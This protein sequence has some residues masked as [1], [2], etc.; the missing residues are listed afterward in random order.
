M[1]QDVTLP[2]YPQSIGAK[3]LSITDHFGP[4]SYNATT[5]DVYNVAGNQNQGG[6]DKV[7]A[8]SSLDGLYTVTS[9]YPA[10]TSAGIG[11]TSVSLFWTFATTG[12]VASVTGT[13]GTGMTVGSFPLVIAA[14]P[15]GG[16]QA[17]GT[18]TVLTATTFTTTISNPGAGYTSAPA[19][20]AATGGTPPT[21]TANLSTAGTAVA[22]GANLSASAVRLEMI[23]Y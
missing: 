11:V 13:G 15:A 1:A 7:N 6:F 23:M 14:P 8:G 9:K 2:G 16:V 5:G 19:T 3:I 20:S 10:G 21:L 4:S 17:V 22:T 18:I 12:S